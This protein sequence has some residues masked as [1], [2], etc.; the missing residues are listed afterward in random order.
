MNIFVSDHCPI[1]S[2]HNLP[3]VLLV[4]MV[5]ESAQLLSTAHHVLD[6]VQVGYKPTHQNHPSNLWCRSTSANYQWLYAHFEALCN[7]YTF[8]TGKTHKT[9]ELLGVLSNLPKNIEQGCLSPFAMVM[10]DEFQRLGLF[11]QTKAYKAYLRQK[12][13]DWACREKPIKLEWTNRIQPEW[14][15]C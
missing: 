11:D 2:A 13:T 7:E 9:S 14:T 5:L 8:R 4:K 6:G 15:K 3:N 10:P 1:Q 12:F